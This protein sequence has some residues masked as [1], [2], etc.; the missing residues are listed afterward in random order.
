MATAKLFVTYESSFDPEY[1]VSVRGDG[2]IS[3]DIYDRY[4]DKF[5]LQQSDNI[6]HRSDTKL[7]HPREGI[8]QWCT[9]LWLK[10]SLGY[11]NTMFIHHENVLL[12]E[13][14]LTPR[15]EDVDEPS[16]EYNCVLL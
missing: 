14:E 7:L 13:T 16:E 4:L 15:Y 1:N 12:D 9:I 11:P 3:R 2:R 10:H 5:I 6:T 8:T